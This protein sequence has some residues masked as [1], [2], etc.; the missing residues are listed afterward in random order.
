ME[1]TRKSTVT[2][3]QEE[4]KEIVEQQVVLEWCSHLFNIKHDK[5]PS[6]IHYGWNWD[7]RCASFEPCT[8]NHTCIIIIMHA[9]N[10]FKCKPDEGT[11]GPCLPL[12]IF[13]YVPKG[14]SPTKKK[15]TILTSSFV[16]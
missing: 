5:A 14:Y 2:I 13:I 15:T 1:K 3:T 7:C 4:N 9:S 10:A 8:Y 16:G 6:S 12:Y 11:H